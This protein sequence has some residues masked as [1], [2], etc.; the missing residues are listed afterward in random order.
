LGRAK[1]LTETGNQ[2]LT[3]LQ[4]PQAVAS[5]DL[6]MVR[7]KLLH[8]A[9]ITGALAV[10]YLVFQ[11]SCVPGTCSR[12][13]MV[14]VNVLGQTCLIVSVLFIFYRLVRRYPS[15]L[16]TAAAIY[17][18]STA[19]FHGF[20]PMSAMV[21]SDAT[22]LFLSSATYVIDEQGLLRTNLL[23]MVGVTTCLLA[24]TLSMRFRIG[25]S[26]V[27]ARASR[28]SL[29]Q[30]AIGFL[31]AGLFIKYGLVLPAQ[32]GLI[33]RTVPG[34]L[35]NLDQLVN[36]G[37]ALLAYLSARKKQGW[38]ILFWT[39]WPIYFGL[40]TLEF[41]KKVLVFAIM[42]PAAGAFLAHRKWLRLVPPVLVSA[43]IFSFFQEVN[44]YGRLSILD[45][46]DT[47]GE[48]TFA[49]RF[50]IQSD[51]FLEDQ[52]LSTLVPATKA[53]AQIWWLRLN[54]AGAQLKGM[55][56]YD[57]GTSGEW[58][59]S[60]LVYFIPRLFWP[61][62]PETVSPGRLFN[63]LASGNIDAQTRVG[64]SVYGDGYW[65]MG[66]FGAVLYPGI[67]GLIFGITTRLSYQQIQLRSLVFLPAI[68]LSLQQAALGPNG[69]LQN[70]V[71]GALPIYF[72]Y[73]FLISLAVRLFSPARRPAL[74]HPSPAYGA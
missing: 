14:G 32:Y 13:F 35:K 51:F 42:L 21:A 6:K 54:Y 23:T 38:A 16:W 55:Q 33:D 52:D 70:S 36:L 3:H 24:M 63:Q 46:S 61:D 59:Q 1:T 8:L 25:G 43:V 28:F 31:G 71:L 18:F 5:R 67:M 44:T 37:F 17:P 49:E 7:K 34:A 20:G 68:M 72:G 9:G 65:Q 2:G 58:L 15:T 41:S 66:W 74:R 60:P 57:E 50:E 45:L 53:A 19:V 40:C 39:L 69:Y 47:R 27:L 30:L 11:V 48:A 22:L 62:K 26:S 73:L 64:M 12:T 29:G 4:T 10:Y 56:F